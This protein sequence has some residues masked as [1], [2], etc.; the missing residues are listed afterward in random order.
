[1]FTFTC[2]HLFFDAMIRYTARL[3]KRNDRKRQR[4]KKGS[5]FEEE[6]LINSL[7]K[8]I[9]RVDATKRK[10]CYAFYSIEHYSFLQKQDLPFLFCQ[11]EIATFPFVGI[12]LAP[13]VRSSRQDNSSTPPFLVP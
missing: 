4:G 11:L 2:L 13:V 9:V 8:L 1:M 3:K 10:Y 5:V 7:R 6:Y 12:S